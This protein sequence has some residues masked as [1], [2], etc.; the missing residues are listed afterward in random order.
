MTLTVQRLSLLLYI[1]MTVLHLTTSCGPSHSS[2]ARLLDVVRIVSFLQVGFRPQHN[3][4]KAVEIRS[5]LFG[6]SRDQAARG[7]GTQT[8]S[9]NVSRQSG[10]CPLDPVQL[11]NGRNPSKHGLLQPG[12]TD[13]SES[14]DQNPEEQLPRRAQS[15]D[16]VW[17]MI[18]YPDFF[19]NEQSEEAAVAHDSAEASPRQ[20]DTM[21]SPKTNDLA[22]WE[23]RTRVVRAKDAAV[24]TSS[25]WPAARNNGI[26]MTQP[27][28]D[29]HCHI[30]LR[31]TGEG[32]GP[33]DNQE[34]DQS[35]MNVPSNLSGFPQAQ[36]GVIMIPPCQAGTQGR[37]AI[38][39]HRSSPSPTFPAAQQG[40][41]PQGSNAS[42]QEGSA[43]PHKSEILKPDSGTPASASLVGQQSYRSR[44]YAEGSTQTWP[45][46]IGEVRGNIPIEQQRLDKAVG[47]AMK[48]S[49]DKQSG[50][51]LQD[52]HGWRNEEAV[53]K[54]HQ[55]GTFETGRASAAARS[56]AVHFEAPRLR[57]KSSMF[58]SKSMLSLFT[59]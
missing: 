34:L 13:W 33:S 7:F 42:A 29:R 48:R 45:N 11:R 2:K 57:G 5:P 15:K 17:H 30:L 35:R 44:K 19:E 49:A 21:N 24:Q 22:A 25:A 16:G 41:K 50:I 20:R 39:T 38:G 27:R 18:R 46:Q 55:R 9:Q 14:R 56:S 52:L 59:L 40:T 51:Q 23:G 58:A 8:W 3:A 32:R 10:L 31:G 53:P 36:T 26:E 1:C 47:T 43:T 37:G 6:K 54:E 12:K 4:Q 28:F